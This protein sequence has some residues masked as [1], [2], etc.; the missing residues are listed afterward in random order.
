MIYDAVG[1][2]N[3]DHS[4][5]EAIQAAGGRVEAFLPLNPLRRRWSVHLRNHRK[6]IVVDGTRGFTGGMNVGD[7]YSGRA[8]RKGATHYQDTHID[9]RGPAVA[10]LEMTF[11]EDWAFSTGEVLDV[12]P[13]PQR[14]MNGTSIVSLVPSGPDQEFNPN[15]MVYFAGIA[16]ARQRVL[17]TCPYFVPH[18]SILQALV[19]AALRGVD[20][21]VMV[22]EK[23]DVMIVGPAARA[24]FPF[25]LRGGVR[26]F[27]YRSSMLHAKTMVVDGLWAVVGSANVDFRSFRLNF[28]LGTLVY[29]PQLAR[30][31]ENCFV[32]DQASSQEVSLEALSRK[33]YAERLW[34]QTARLLSP[35]L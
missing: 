10:D 25:L 31:L 2:L 11:I 8:R 29:D 13:P 21:R 7:E 22:P 14:E 33:S 20:V 16:S 12:H 27:E 24:S 1:S 5:L 6:L 34:E 3:I 19:S 26:I 17:L 23:C 28:E 32:A 15:E 18:G 35:V 4:R 9:I 30:S